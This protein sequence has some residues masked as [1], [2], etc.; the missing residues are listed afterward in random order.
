MI[1]RSGSS[2]ETQNCVKCHHRT[3]DYIEYG[4][5]D[6][7]SIKIPVCDECKE[8]MS[9]LFSSAKVILPI[10]QDAVTKSII[11]SYD[12]NYIGKLKKGGDHN[13]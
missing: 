8:S 11:I 5:K 4:Y 9:H 3:G 13:A 12:E 2:T 1:S 10:I 6:G 7:I